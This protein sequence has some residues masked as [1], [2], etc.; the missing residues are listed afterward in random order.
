MNAWMLPRAGGTLPLAAT[1]Q[2][3]SVSG[4]RMATIGR[5]AAMVAITPLVIFLVPGSAYW[6]ELFFIALVALL[7]V[8]HY[9]TVRRRPDRLWWGFV[10]AVL[11]AGIIVCVLIYPNPLI[12]AGWPP[13]MQL[14]NGVVV[15]MF[16]VVALAGLAYSPSLTLWTGITL[17]VA[18]ALGIAWAVSWPGSITA[19]PANV[20]PSIESYLALILS[21]GFIDLNVHFQSVFVLLVVTVILAGI[22]W[23]S[24]RL[25]LRQASTAREHANLARYFPPGIVEQ[26]SNQERPLEQTREQQGAVLFTDIVG[27]TGMVEQMTAFEMIGFLRDY[28]RR[29]EETVF[30]HGGTLDKFLGDG[31]MATFGTPITA[32][33]DA[34][35]A[36]KCAAA[37]LDV[38]AAWNE[39]RK[40]AGAAP[41]RVSVGAHY[42]PVVLGNIGSERRLEFAV[43]GDVVNVASRLEEQTRRLGAAALLSDDLV[44]K[45][46]QEAAAA[47]LEEP[48]FA[49][50]RGVPAQKLRG[51]DQDVAAWIIPRGGENGAEPQP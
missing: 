33:E 11:D 21:K 20:E 51:R 35:D 27:F 19:L 13:Q 44:A 47:G 39:E 46:K 37:I 22:V 49:R 14:R 34:L 40:Q 1:F 42:G 3:E 43:L 36:V 18:W 10:F 25:V 5:T 41:V 6:F 23:R 30:Q 26:L 8:V 15:Y 9:L 48:V 45:A 4:L 28:H 7:G 32:P 38:A 50:L 24:R 31:I 17:A 16:I 2:Q 29:L 12:E